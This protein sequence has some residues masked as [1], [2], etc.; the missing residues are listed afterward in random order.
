MDSPQCVSEWNINIHDSGGGHG[1]R[2]NPLIRLTAANN[3]SNSGNLPH[4]CRPRPCHR[5]HDSR[6]ACRLVAAYPFVSTVHLGGRAV[7]PS[8][9]R[10]LYD[11]F[12]RWDNHEMIGCKKFYDDQTYLVRYEP[13]L[14]PLFLWT[15]SMRK[16]AGVHSMPSLKPKPDSLVLVNSFCG[17]EPAKDVPPLLQSVGPLLSDGYTPLDD[18]THNFLN[19]KNSVVYVAFGTHVILTPEKLARLMRGH[20]CALEQGSIDG[21]IWDQRINIPSV[22]F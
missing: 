7:T 20:C 18:T 15:R 22:I 11:K 10:Q 12:I 17:L 9:D 13:Q 8:E 4:F 1:W 21:I 6:R 5:V 14:L 3:S 19:T 16:Q 2:G